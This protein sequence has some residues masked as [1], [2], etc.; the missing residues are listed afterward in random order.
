MLVL[1]RTYK[2]IDNGKNCV[3]FGLGEVQIGIYNS[4][5]KLIVES[6]VILRGTGQFDVGRIGAFTYTSRNDVFRYVEQIGRFCAIGEDVVAGLPEY[7]VRNVTVHPLFDIGS[8][9][10]GDWYSFQP[11]SPN[12]SVLKKN[13]KQNRNPKKDEPITIGNDVWIGKN[14]MI[15]RGVNIG[16]GAVIAA[17]AV[18]VKDVPPYAVVGGNPARIIRYRFEDSVIERLLKLQWW[19]YGPEIMRGIDITQIQS[20]MAELENRAKTLPLFSSCE[21]EF[22]PVEKEIYMLKD[23]NRALM[24]K[25]V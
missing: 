17:G 18:V 4:R 25:L 19:N 23:G 7:N 21:F 1:D 12:Y 16:D 5:R 20:A 24:Y 6:P 11:D 3:S 13:M 9:F 10:F 14:A 2:F 22:C 8:S 15:L